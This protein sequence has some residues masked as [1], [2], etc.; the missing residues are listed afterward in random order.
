MMPT[1][2]IKPIQTRYRGHH[3]RSRL[4]ARWA[5]FFDALMIPWEYEPEG[6]NLDV[7]FYLPDFR[8]TLPIGRVVWCEVK[9]RH[10]FTSV[11]L[12]RL[13]AAHDVPGSCRLLSG[14]PWDHFGGKHVCPRCCEILTTEEGHHG[15][16]GTWFDEF[17]EGGPLMYCFPCDNE[18]PGGGG[19][20][21]VSD[22]IAGVSYAPSKGDIQITHTELDRFYLAV[23]KACDAARSARFEHGECGAT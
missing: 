19:H 14:D 7:E 20:E 17:V 8:L 23:E 22:G 4:E 2:S 12:D 16:W 15:S 1:T 9:P 5:V 6:F 10:E 11:K 21:T 18:T 13:I 3:F